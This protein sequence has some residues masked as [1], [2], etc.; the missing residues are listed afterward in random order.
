MIDERHQ[1]L[2]VGGGAAGLATA[3]GAGYLGLDVALVERGR[4]GGE[5]TW[6]GC[7]P[8][9][10]LIDVARRVHD[11]AEP[12]DLGLRTHRADVDF[13]AVMRHV[14]SV[15]EEVAKYENEDALESAGVELYRGEARFLDSHRVQIGRAVTIE[16]GQIVIATGADPVVP[17]GLAP[18]EP[19]TSKTFWDLDT[20]PDVLLV[21]GGGSVASELGQALSRLGSEVQMITDSDRLIPEDHPDAS[22][23]LGAAFAKE[24]IDVL[25][26][27]TATRAERAGQSIVVETDT[28]ARL[29]GSH[30]L[31]AVGTRPNLV[32]LD[33]EA[34]GLERNAEGNLELDA[35]LRTSQPHIFAAGDVAGG[36]FTHM[37][38]DHARTIVKN[39]VLPIRRA[40]SAVP[41]WATF[42]DPEIAQV[43][44]PDL[45]VSRAGGNSTR[46]P[47]TRVDKAMVSAHRDGFIEAH[48]TNTGKIESVTIVG[49]DA[50]ELSNQW[51]PLIGHRITKLLDTRTIYP[52]MGSSMAILG[53]EWIKSRLNSPW[54]SVGRWL[55]KLWVWPLSTA[56]NL[57][58][59]RPADG[60][61]RVR[62]P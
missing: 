61:P 31:V 30:L 40:H 17:H 47:L 53:S 24:G 34:A 8:S 14:R 49:P 45:E 21:A 11:S 15:S 12:G 1:L 35:S 41:R 44:V 16:A 48:H 29:H 4:L 62:A 25:T 7:I 26:R 57:L 39:I 51:V 37:G 3:F 18:A 6:W 42:T 46:L 50:S 20:L 32:G 56:R 2:V 9:K 23:L 38:T 27:E 59:R 54:G 10:T 52:T 55:I 60:P 19:L 22:R 43:G 36:G 28:G 58:R 5:C 13:P 33:V